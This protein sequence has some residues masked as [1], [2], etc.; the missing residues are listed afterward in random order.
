MHS[1]DY[2]VTLIIDQRKLSAKIRSTTYNNY[3]VYLYKESKKYTI[4]IKLPSTYSHK[5]RIALVS[6]GKM[7]IE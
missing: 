5:S 2:S 3:N 4:E 1:P 7:H 6:T